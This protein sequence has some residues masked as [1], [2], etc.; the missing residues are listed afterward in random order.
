MLFV[1][2]HQ[3]ISNI[4]IKHQTSNIKWATRRKTIAR[5]VCRASLAGALRLHSQRKPGPRG[6][7]AIF[8]WCGCGGGSTMDGPFKTFQNFL[9][10]FQISKLKL[11][12]QKLESDRPPQNFR[13]SLLRLQ[14]LKMPRR[15]RKSQQCRVV[16][17]PKYWKFGE[18]K[19]AAFKT[20]LKSVLRGKSRHLPLDPHPENQST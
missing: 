15:G 14:I 20:A 2:R 8:V 10:N 9:P 7:L 19:S 3:I 18:K 4:N 11:P 6:C 13:A 16:W 17:I 1:W 5:V 12:P